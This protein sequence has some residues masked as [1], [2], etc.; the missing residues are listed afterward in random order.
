MRNAVI[1]RHSE[2]FYFSWRRDSVE[3]AKRARQKT[4]RYAGA[5]RKL[6]K[7]NHL[8]NKM[9]GVQAKTL[10]GKV[11]IWPIRPIVCRTQSGCVNTT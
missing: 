3:L 7:N 10:K 9:L 5:R 4:T 6:Y 11:I 1:R 2:I 8:S